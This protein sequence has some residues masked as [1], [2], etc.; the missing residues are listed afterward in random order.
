MKSLEELK[1]EYKNTNNAINISSRDLATAETVDALIIGAGLY[2]LHIGELLNKN[3]ITHKIVAKNYY[4]DYENEFYSTTNSRIPMA[5][6]VNGAKIDSGYMDYTK[7]VD[8]IKNDLTNYTKF[9]DEFNDELMVPKDYNN[10]YALDE[11]SNEDKNWAKA[12]R[13][14]KKKYNAEETYTNTLINVR[15]MYNINEAAI[16]PFRMMERKTYNY[17]KGSVNTNDEGIILD[18]I[19]KAVRLDD[20]WYIKLSEK[21]QLIKAKYIFNCTYSGIKEIEKIFN[22]NTN[23]NLVYD[24][25]E[26]VLFTSGIMDEYNLNNNAFTILLNKD[27]FKSIT[28]FCYSK[29]ITSDNISNWV[30]VDETYNKFAESYDYNTIHE[31]FTCGSLRTNK[32]DML[33]SIRPYVGLLDKEKYKKSIFTIKAKDVDNKDNNLIIENDKTNTFYSILGNKLS[34]IYEL[35]EIINNI[36][37]EKD[38]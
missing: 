10:L 37:S 14:I 30:F 5:S 8:I 12:I 4:L 26:L 11:I 34:S 28:P 15:E 27:K 3:N 17:L 1:K 36:F 25:C 21:S 13:N 20:Y 31:E 6:L 33:K 35:N 24:I 16:D 32:L 9:I 2:G 18:E 29:I 23:I 7:K 19:S 22:I 38:K